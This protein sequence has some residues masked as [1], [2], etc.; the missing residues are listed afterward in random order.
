M[1][2][3]NL[4]YAYLLLGSIL[5][6][7]INSNSFRN[8]DDLSFITNSFTKEAFAEDF[9]Y[10]ACYNADF[11]D[12]LPSDL[13]PITPFSKSI[14]MLEETSK[15][16]LVT[17][18]TNPEYSNTIIRELISESTITDFESGDLS[19]L[20][21]S[22]VDSGDW[23][24]F[25]GTGV[26]SG[27]YS[28]QS[29]PLLGN[30]SEARLGYNFTVPPGEKAVIS[31]DWDIVTQSSGYTLDRA[32][33]ILDG[34]I[35]LFPDVFDSSWKTYSV[36]ILT[37]GN[38]YIEWVYTTGGGIV[39]D[40]RARIDNITI[41]RYSETETLV[42]SIY[43]KNLDIID[44]SS[45]T[46]SMNELLPIN[47]L[48]N[49]LFTWRPIFN[50]NSVTQSENIFVNLDA[51]FFNEEYQYSISKLGQLQIRVENTNTDPYI[52]NLA[53]ISEEY[54]IEEN[55]TIDLPV[56]VNIVDEDSDLLD[57][58]FEISQD[59]F[60]TI[61][62]SFVYNNVSSLEPI[63]H[64]FTNLGEGEYT[65]RVTS[66]ESQLQN[67]CVGYENELSPS[68]LTIQS[69]SDEIKISIAQSDPDPDPDPSST[70]TVTGIIYSDNNRNGKQDP[71]EKG[72][73]NITVFA[74]SQSI[75][76]ETNIPNGFEKILSFLTPSVKASDL[77]RVENVTDKDGV[78]TFF[79]LPPGEITITIDQ[80]DPDIPAGSVLTEGYFE[81]KL[82]V[83]Q[84]KV[85]TNTGFTL[86]NNPNIIEEDPNNHTPVL[87]NKDENISKE[88]PDNYVAKLEDTGINIIILSTLGILSLMA[89]FLNPKKIFSHLKK[90]KLRK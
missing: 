38:H 59:N 16:V 34:D 60:N 46:V 89:T 37:P 7:N 79:E 27:T 33:V 42:P 44:I 12:T 55:E 76:A 73:P 78:F 47:T 83:L 30:N 81:R 20:N 80:N 19:P 85:S 87:E 4:I 6:A 69:Q 72:L 50:I 57:V 48:E 36:D 62:Q 65:W 9:G 86:F 32:K 43:P 51:K 77:Q 10:S 5:F 22:V 82:I 71:D 26:R 28:A 63:P 2:K 68:P 40:D 67:Y 70:V 14:C 35:V 53:P 29:S 75:L 23:E 21:N 64:I 58:T 52:N 49:L 41:D 54:T 18:G 17:A 90:I 13:C 1:N 74:S 84:G 66:Q 88:N 3:K 56:S 31:F 15:E 45:N 25:S 61:E 24:V 8:L 11:G 39:Y